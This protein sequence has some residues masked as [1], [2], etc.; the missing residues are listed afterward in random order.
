MKE[1]NHG[2]TQA[3]GETKEPEGR[4]GPTTRARM[5]LRVYIDVHSQEAQGSPPVGTT[6]KGIRDSIHTVRFKIFLQ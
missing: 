6:G 1:A 5:S 4:V 3:R 2:D